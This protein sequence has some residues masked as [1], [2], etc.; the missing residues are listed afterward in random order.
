MSD[1]MNALLSELGPSAISMI[2]KQIGA[3]ESMTQ[4]AVPVVLAT[5]LGSMA[6]NT[7][8]P[9]GAQSLSNALSSD[10]DGSILGDIA[11]FV[12]NSS[13]GPG[14]S[15]LGHILGTQQKS[16]ESEVANSTGMSSQSITKLL[17]ILA[18]IVLGYLGKQ[19]SS[20]G[21]NAGDLASV[22]LG[23]K[24]K[25]SENKPSDMGMLGGLLDADNDGDISDDVASLG[26][27]VLGS[28]FS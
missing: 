11:G 6:H 24:Q 28:L 17:A 27:K 23:E 19:K 4:K 2:S 1:V 13:S 15:I 10:H 7:Q 16:V 12:L 9:S 22:L 8:A 21:W 3:E 5:L 20:Q 25:L 14:A 26:I 18:P